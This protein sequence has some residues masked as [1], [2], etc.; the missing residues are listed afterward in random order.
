MS[1]INIDWASLGFA[2]MQTKCHIQY[3]WKDGKWDEGRLVESPYIPIHIAAGG[4]HYGQECFEGMKVF[5]Q[6][7]GSVSIFRVQE[8]ARRMYNTAERLCMAPVPVE[9]FE[10]A[11]RRVVQA[12]VDY[13]PPYGTGGSLYVRPLLFGS[14]P[15]IGVA[16]SHE[17]TFI[18][19]V[20]PVGAYYKGG[21]KPVKA[22]VLDDYDRAA[23]L[24]TGHIKC[25]G[26]YGASLYAHE[27]A[28]KMG[29][30]VELYLDAKTHTY[31]DEFATSNFLAITKDGKYVTPKSHTV[32]PSVT[33][34]TLMQ[35][36]ADFGMPVE[37]RPID[38]EKEIDTFAEVAACGTA[39]VVTPV[40][41]ITRNGK[42][43]VTGPEDGCGPILEKFYH[44]VQDI[45]YGVA[46]DTHGWNTKIC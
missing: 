3:T 35:I 21:L 23:P 9:L 33:N 27:L 22:I 29:Y 15:Q 17:Y 8:N 24:G 40:C 31:I 39:V 43:H 46:P 2:Y 32:L 44:A 37:H 12:N 10:E 36:A 14:G 1:N 13:V 19:L 4:L 26:N 38:F 45:Q 6:K 34:K 16:P 11:C 42:T 25:G 18:I 7:D 28:K 30:P 41:S 5:R 20:T